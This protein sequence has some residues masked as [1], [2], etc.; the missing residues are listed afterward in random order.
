MSIDEQH[1]ALAA[2]GQPSTPPLE[3]AAFVLLLEG[4]E[5]VPAIDLGLPTEP[6]QPFALSTMPTISD[7]PTA[8]SSPGSAFDGA[9]A[10]FDPWRLGLWVLPALAA[11][12]VLWRAWQQRRS[13]ERAIGPAG[14]AREGDTHDHQG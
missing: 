3:V 7:V 4:A 14:T 2:E 6:P 11:G 5:W 13:R 1:V 9:A 10:G 12:I 8:D